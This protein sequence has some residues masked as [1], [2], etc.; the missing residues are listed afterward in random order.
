MRLSLLQAPIAVLL[1][2]AFA[3]GGLE[4][5][6]A[7]DCA[8]SPPNL[9]HFYQSAWGIG[10]NSQ[11]YQADTSIDAGN[12]A[13]LQLKWSYGFASQSPRVFPLVTPDTIFIGDA[14]YG[15]VALDRETGCQR[16]VNTDAEDVVTSV[17]AG[18]LDGRTVLVAAGRMTGIY[19]VDA[20]TGETIWQRYV[21]DDNPVPMFSGS[22]MVYEQQVFVPI[23]SMEI[24]LSANPIYGCCT[25]SGAVAALDLAT[26]ATKWYLR[27]IPDQAEVVGRHYFF[28]E[29]RGPSGAP[30]WNAPT[31]DEARRLLYFGTGQNYSH[32]T[33]DT[34]D[35]IFAVDIDTGEPRWISQF[36]E[37][38][39][40]NM[41]CTAGGIN[42]P[43]PMGP[44]VDFG[45]PPI[46]ARLADGSDV[47]L[48]GQ[49][50]G[51]VW[52]IN[53][54]TGET[55]WH[56]R[57]GRGGA[58]GGIH[59]GMA[60][61]PEQG[62]LFVPISDRA[63]LEGELEAEPGMFALSIETGERVWSEPR[64]QRCEGRYCW[65]GLSSGIT[66][67]P[68]IIVTG[69]LDGMLEIYDSLDGKLLWSFDTLTD[70]QTVN[71]VPASGGAI[72]THGPTLADDLLIAVSG[73]QTFGQKP[74]NAPLV[75]EL[76]KAATEDSQAE[77]QE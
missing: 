23:S 45:A 49:K 46:L 62:L 68:G 55:I 35:A 59:W 27:T 72:D 42:C 51:D 25:T 26:G 3:Y 43:D 66:A 29:R 33:T 4:A 20:L 13:S 60:V 73:Y 64:V 63:A 58:L 36:T 31:L 28:V 38:D 17:S 76:P 12:A 24:A 48:A 39:A 21:D 2:G 47:L 40:F 8:A 32:P 67:G 65:S 7:E 61:A 5:A 18:V 11:R 57:I 75:F 70:F 19:A 10:Y 15:L 34:S 69:A 71:D 41:A 14:G 50:S 54:D 9:D 1:C 44:D 52:A 56:Q 6:G 53:P 77:R 74:G 30:V 16:W 22:P 37:G